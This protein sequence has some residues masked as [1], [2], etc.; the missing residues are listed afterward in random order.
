MGPTSP[1]VAQP[2]SSMMSRFKGR[3]LPDGKIQIL[4]DGKEFAIVNSLEDAKSLIMK[5]EAPP[6][7]PPKTSAQTTSNRALDKNKEMAKQPFDP[8]GLML[9]GLGIFVCFIGFMIAYSMA[10]KRIEEPNDANEK[11]N[12]ENKNNAANNPVAIPIA[13]KD[14]I[15]IKRIDLEI[16]LTNFS[17]IKNAKQNGKVESIVKYD[18]NVKNGSATK[19]ENIGVC[20]YRG[21]REGVWVE[22]A[23]DFGNRIET[24]PE[25]LTSIIGIERG[26]TKIPPGE[27][28]TREMTTEG[29]MHISN[30]LHGTLGINTT[31]TL[32]F[33][34]DLDTNKEIQKK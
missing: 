11:A 12:K 32:Q 27:T 17:V 10:P 5:L 34:V 26:A 30:K 20:N 7:V 15:I 16:T 6:V 21:G 31:T 2:E 14:N 22:F 25:V 9:F 3:N 33:I 1:F 13:G 19:I 23:D 28:E 18:V 4:Q 29:I 24:K 8:A